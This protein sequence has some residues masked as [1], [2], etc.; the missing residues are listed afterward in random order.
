MKAI[1]RYIEGLAFVGKSESN[2]WVTIDGPKEFSGGD[3][4][5]HP[6]ELVLLALGGCTGGDVVSI[7]TKKKVHLQGFEIHIDA[8]RSDTH[9]KVFTKIHIE[10][11][12]IGHELNVV[13]VRR[14]IDLSQQK[15]CSV[16]AM[17][18][19][20]VPISTSYQIL[21]GDPPHG[22]L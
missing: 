17:L 4:A 10:Y 18:R 8:E 1:L 16:S 11:V 21:E 13:H 3:A 2:H 9:P 12:F 19:S 7:L 6:M 5:V 15:Y 20:S 22:T 14:A